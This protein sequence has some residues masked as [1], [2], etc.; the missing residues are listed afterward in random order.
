MIDRF[1]PTCSRFRRERMFRVISGHAGG[2]GSNLKLAR[3]CVE[4]EDARIRRSK[5]QAIAGRP[6]SDVSGVD[7]DAIHY[8]R[9][10]VKQ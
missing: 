2:F 1:C 9:G 8:K 4:C 6:Q 3:D 10:A 5:G 7:I